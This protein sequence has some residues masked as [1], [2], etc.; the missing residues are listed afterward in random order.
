MSNKIVQGITLNEMARKLRVNKSKLSYYVSKGLIKPSGS[1]GG[2]YVF[3]KDETLLALKQ[4]KQ[5]QRKKYSLEEIKDEL[6]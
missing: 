5:L 3:D 2:M 6:K 1:L 4:I